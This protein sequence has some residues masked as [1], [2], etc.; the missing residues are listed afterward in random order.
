MVLKEAQEAR[1]N[2]G[3]RR[4]AERLREQ[5]INISPEM[6]RSRLKYLENKGLVRIGK[7]R[8]GSKLTEEGK[9]LLKNI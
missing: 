1:I 5:G 8:Q 2:I 9:K 6:V 3:R 7:T 4:I